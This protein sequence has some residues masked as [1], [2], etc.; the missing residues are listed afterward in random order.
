VE[1]AVLIPV[2]L[3]IAAAV[4]GGMIWS[5]Y[6]AKRR[7]EELA[8]LAPRLGLAYSADDCCGI[9]RRF[10]GFQALD[11]GHSRRA[12]N[13]LYGELAGREAYAFDYNY[14]T[15]QTY[16]NKSGTHTREVDHYL[17]AAVIGCDCRFPG[18]FIRP[19]RFLD[20]LAGLVGFEDIDFESHEFSKRF[21]VKSPD[22][23]FAYDVIHPQM[24]EF[25][26]RCQG[27]SLEVSGSALIIWTGSTWKPPDFAAGL[28]VL[29]GFLDRVP[30]FLWKQLGS[31]R[32]AARSRGP[33]PEAA[34]S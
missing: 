4:I 24:M 28:Q 30:H 16:T 20:K 21:Y 31:E 7:R 12:Y 15:T 10:Q 3:L 27:W 22:R 32:E 25:L 1:G 33:Q 29:G 18:L 9:V 19:E 14:K 2:F 26:L 17:S 23:K 13:L 8:A 5:W 34:G 11:Q 6:A